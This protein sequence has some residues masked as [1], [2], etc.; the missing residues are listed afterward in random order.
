MQPR[1]SASSNAP[2]GGEAG[3]VWPSG[4][5][6]PVTAP[7][8]VTRPRQTT[9]STAAAH[10]DALRALPDTLAAMGLY[11][12]RQTAGAT[13]AAHDERNSSTAL[14]GAL[15]LAL[16]LP[17]S[18]TIATI[19]WDTLQLAEILLTREDAA[20][21][22]AASTTKS[23]GVLHKR[24][25][26]ELNL[27]SMRPGVMEY[28][29][30]ASLLPWKEYIAS[31]PQSDAI[32]GQGITRASLQFIVGVIDPN[33]C[34]HLRI[35]YVFE[36]IG[37]GH[38]RL[39]PGS[40]PKGDAK[41]IFV[42]P[43]ERRG[44]YPATGIIFTPSTCWDAAPPNHPNW[45]TG[46]ESAV[47]LRDLEAIPKHIQLGK[48]S[49]FASLNDILLV[50]GQVDITDGQLWPWW[51]WIANLDLEHSAIVVGPGI[52]HAVARSEETEPCS[53]S[54]C[55]TRADSSDIAVTLTKHGNIIKTTSSL[56]RVGTQ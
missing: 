47:T 5:A 4:Y 53:V 54:L 9:A 32:I 7:A 12:H 2:R 18:S 46:A 1:S 22:K 17:T 38:C 21:L 37:G 56:L 42:H 25:R 40:K 6:G 26:D 43:V 39:H 41:L 29:L 23:Y 51:R 13:A 45:Q 16:A 3:N 33:R 19:D 20:H 11:N 27:D 55:L 48:K 49:A 34:G 31:H 8:A 44:G 15:Q 10:A 36:W 14:P 30:D 24:M 50:H 28:E 35:D 52:T